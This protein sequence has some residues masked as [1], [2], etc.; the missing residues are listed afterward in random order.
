MKFFLL[1]SALLVLQTLLALGQGKIEMAIPGT[2]HLAAHEPS[3]GIFLLPCFYGRPVKVN[4]H[5][6]AGEIGRTINERIEK[7]FAGNSARA[8]D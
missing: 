3:V 8:V 7:R 6:L 2:W 4:Y 1:V 5:I